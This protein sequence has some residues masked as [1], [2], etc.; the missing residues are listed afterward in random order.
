MSSG[1][2]V[3]GI[4][5]LSPSGGWHLRNYLDEIAPDLL[6]QCDFPVQ[7]GTRVLLVVLSVI[8]RFVPDVVGRRGRVF[9]TC[10][11]GQLC[12]EP[13]RIAAFEHAYFGIRP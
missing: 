5:H 11:G 6:D 12:I 2:H 1:P 10:P 3:F 9:D 4:R 13:C 8:V 7:I